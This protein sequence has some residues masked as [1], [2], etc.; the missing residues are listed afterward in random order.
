[1]RLTP[2][3][4]GGAAG[5]GGRTSSAVASPSAS[6]AAAEP[7]TSLVWAPW[8]GPKLRATASAASSASPPVLSTCDDGSVTAWGTDGECIA[9]VTLGGSPGGDAEPP[10]PPS[11]GVLDA[12]AN[13]T[14]PELV[15]WACSDGAVRVWSRLA[16]RVG[17]G[18]PASSAPG[19]AVTA[20]RWS[21]DGNYLAAGSE[22][23]GCAVWSQS[24]ELQSRL[25][26]SGGG[27]GESHPCVYALRWA[28]DGATI[29][30][31]A[32]A[33][34]SIVAAWP[35][36]A[37]AEYASSVSPLM[38]PWAAHDGSLVRCLDWCAATDRLVSGGEDGT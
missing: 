1:M 26:L 5:G 21:A 18:W 36:A 15:A 11:Y 33:T 12:H 16:G 17:V 23:G 29:A 27:S 35:T 32:G 3:S 19:I 31:A 2:L 25:P 13:P 7:T 20:L 24:G 8:R 34:L 9:S 22:D 6:T 4:R 14:A 10:S 28:A 38:A 37:S 30:V